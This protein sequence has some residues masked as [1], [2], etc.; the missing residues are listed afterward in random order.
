MFATATMAK[1]AYVY[2]VQP[3]CYRAP[4]FCLA[5]IGTDNKFDGKQVMPRWNYIYTECKMWGI[6]VLEKMGTQ[7]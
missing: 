6:S 2:I 3:L 7:E 4:P 1:Y 5:C